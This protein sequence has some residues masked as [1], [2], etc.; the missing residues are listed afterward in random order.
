VSNLAAREGQLDL[1]DIAPSLLELLG[2]AVQPG[3]DGR[4]AWAGR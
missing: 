4:S 2:L 3:L 1:V